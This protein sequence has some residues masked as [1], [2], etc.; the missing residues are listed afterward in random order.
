[1]CQH[2]TKQ[3]KGEL[4]RNMNLWSNNNNRFV[5]M[6]IEYKEFYL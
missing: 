3:I 1:M 4:R 6:I 2:L 5:F